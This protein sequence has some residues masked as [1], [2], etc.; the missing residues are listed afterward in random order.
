MPAVLRVAV[1]VPLAQGFDYLPPAESDPAA[2]AVG[3]RLAVP[4]AGRTRVGV[5]VG[6]AQDSTVDAHKLRHALRVLDAAPLISAELS[7]TLA[8][9]ARYYQHPLGEVFET[10]LPVGLRSPR[11]LPA[12]ASGE[13]A[14]IRTE[15]SAEAANLP[16]AGSRAA[17]L[18]ELL[19]AGPHSHTEL[20]L[21]LPGWRSAAAN[22][23]KRGLI[24]TTQLALRTLPRAQVAGP[25]LTEEQA[26][27]VA[28][29]AAGFGGFGPTLLEG[30]TGSGKTEVYLA[31]IEQ[32]VARGGQALVLVPEI[33]LTPQTLR[34]FRERL[35]A[36]IEVIHSGLAD[37]E[38]TRAWL[39]AARGEADVVIGTR[40][41]VFAPLPNAG[42]IIV[43]EE[44]DGSYKQQE[45]W[46]YSARDLALVRAR[47]LAVPV[48]LGTATP[49]LETLANVEAGRYA[50]RN[51]AA[52][53]GVARL[54]QFRL[55]DL[56]GKPLRHG[57]AD[58]TVAAL[59]TCLA[60]GEQA[61]VFRNR[62][63]YA[64]VLTCR[65]CGWHA[66][67]ARCDK[68]LT[69][70]RGAARLRCHH[71][72]AEQRV[73]SI[74]PQCNNVH[75]APQGLG[76]ER[77]EAALAEI[78]PQVPLVRIDRETTRR[79]NALDELLGALAPDRAALVVGTQML[80]KGH[81]LPNLTLV[82][83][84]GVD[85]GLFSV[86]FRAEERLAQL[87]VQ[88]AGRAG[89]ALKPGQVWLQTHH[90][91]HPLLRTLL[92]HGYA[93]AAQRLLRE[94]REAHLPPYAH[95]ALLRA[96]A[97]QQGQVDEF[98]HAAAVLAARPDG[99]GLL[100]PM[101][102]PMPRRAGLQRGQ[103]LVSADERARLHAFLAGW[104]AGVRGLREARRVR[105]SLDVDPVDL[106]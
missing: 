57:L 28:A 86:D 78:F 42:L 26:A 88:V 99:V 93:A 38:R 66:A 44:H 87:V 4:F 52:R 90:P 60:R 102:A 32:V 48:V 89:R 9:A 46:R 45:G 54:P 5:V 20:D 33:G 13:R 40:S 24:A 62:R 55:V 72:D 73:P 15:G 95:L 96:D 8:W 50:K 3:M 58:E 94:R 51:L 98:L 21:R 105:W 18:F 49:S 104:I 75:L 82:V 83:I 7:A 100:G 10:A 81:D 47:A 41:A 34:R 39:A 91:D 22:L 76:T 80:A 69:W 92:S 74:C 14:L 17:A 97:A 101:P 37:G 31:L 85:E 19:G 59:R 56:R 43:D 6:H 106:Y 64:P 103:L 30:I 70:H 79:K 53:P 65:Q 63:G 61:L 12:I 71:C 16:R 23:R 67:C 11:P 36:R 68:P 1:A 77:I 84:V 25:Q 29:V 35:G 2:I 27:A